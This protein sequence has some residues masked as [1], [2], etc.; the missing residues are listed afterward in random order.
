MDT[1]DHPGLDDVASAIHDA[2]DA[3]HHLRDIAP[4]SLLGDR[5]GDDDEGEDEEVG[6]FDSDE[7]PGAA[8]APDDGVNTGPDT[9]EPSASS[10]PSSP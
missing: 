7:G 10:A 3:E 8:G 1:H 5:D 9:T 2:K 6:W 4:S